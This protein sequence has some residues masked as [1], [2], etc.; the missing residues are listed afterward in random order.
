MRSD[1]TLSP[2]MVRTL[3]NLRDGLPID[4]HVN[5]RSEAG[6]FRRTLGGLVA[7]GLIEM[8]PD[9][10]GYILTAAGRAAVSE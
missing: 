8:D 2:G 1:A 5:G 6:G 10:P 4:N 9:G 3:R 7:R